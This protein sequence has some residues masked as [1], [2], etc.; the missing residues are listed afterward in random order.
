MRKL[1]NYLPAGKDGRPAW[2]A[3]S[4]FWQL[5]AGQIMQAH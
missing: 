5:L 4:V 1:E 3:Q 2:P